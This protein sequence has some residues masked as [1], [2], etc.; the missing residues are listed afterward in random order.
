ME[1]ECRSL[2]HA[3]K[4]TKLLRVA[5]CSVKLEKI[6]SSELYSSDLKTQ[7]A[8]ERQVGMIGEVIIRLKQECHDEIPEFTDQIARFGNRIINAFDSIDNSIVWVILKRYLDPLK[9][10]V[11]K[12]NIRTFANKYMVNKSLASLNSI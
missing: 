9:Q 3:M 7:S 4:S 6:D 11:K 12:E 2:L 10:E 8:V 1:G 5:D